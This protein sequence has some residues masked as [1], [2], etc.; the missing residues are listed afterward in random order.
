MVVNRQVVLARTIGGSLVRSAICMER[1]SSGSG[2]E[3]G[4]RRGITTI[5]CSAGRSSWRLILRRYVVSG[6][7]RPTSW[8]RVTRPLLS[9]STVPTT[10]GFASRVLLTS[11]SVS[12]GG[13]CLRRLN[14]QAP[15]LHRPTDLPSIYVYGLPGIKSRADQQQHR[16]SPVPAPRPS[17]VHQAHHRQR[18]HR[19]RRLHVHAIRR[20]RRAHRDR[21][22]AARL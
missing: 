1:R 18:W 17:R 15:M 5:A 6:L 21:H 4:A 14:R 13:S 2:I 7:P 16:K 11:L 22:H 8:L 19:R 10:T 9:T 20:D 3:P 12:N